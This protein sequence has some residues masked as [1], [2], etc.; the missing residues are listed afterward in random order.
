MAILGYSPTTPFN[1]Y[2]N[3]NDLQTTPFYL[4]RN[5]HVINREKTQLSPFKD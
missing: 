1:N 5:I 3:I 2:N 4:I